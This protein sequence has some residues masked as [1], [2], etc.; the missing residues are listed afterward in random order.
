ME[1]MTKTRDIQPHWMTA[2]VHLKNEFM[3]DEKY[4]NSMTWL[5]CF[6]STILYVVILTVTVCHFISIIMM[7]DGILETPL[8]SFQSYK[9]N[10]K[11]VIKGSVLSDTASNLKSLVI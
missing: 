11:V 2:H 6:L 10:G 4:H 3:E 7:C 5:N 8:Y 9:G 1:G